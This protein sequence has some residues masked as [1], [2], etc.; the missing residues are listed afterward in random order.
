[1]RMTC[2]KSSAI[3]ALCVTLV[4]AENPTDGVGLVIGGF[5]GGIT[6]EAITADAICQAPIPEAPTGNIEGWVSEVMDNEIWLCGG[7]D[8]NF[9]AECYSIPISGG[10]W[11][12]QASLQKA[13]EYA[14]SFV[15]GD[16]M[17]ILGGYN[18][19]NGW[20]DEVERYDPV[21][22]TWEVM[23]D[24]TLPRKLFNLCAL[25]MDDTHIIIAGGNEYD[26]AYR[27]LVDILDITT[28][29]WESAEPLP[30]G[31]AAHDCIN[32]ELEG[33]KGLL[34][35]GGCTDA[36]QNHANETLFFSY[37]DRSWTILAELNEKKMGH[38][39]TWLDG[40]VAVIG[41]YRD[42]LIGNVEVFDGIEWT[43]RSD[44]LTF[45]RWAFG[46]PDYIPSGSSIGC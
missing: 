18:D 14:S 10:N 3:L 39:M 6:I 1:M 37:T 38:K 25:P 12:E 35:T 24:W 46:L 44:S 13:R 21:S 45:A 36:C 32:Y 4:C 43:V 20:L 17:V 42:S 29:V 30:F 33:E 7:S 28:G 19:R 27:D 34:M 22:K 26:Q 40:Q 23:T 2:L 41:G 15:M 9:R 11:K 5:G 8:L 31:R 16:Q